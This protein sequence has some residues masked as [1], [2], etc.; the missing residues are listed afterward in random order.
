[1]MQVSHLSRQDAPAQQ[2]LRSW[3][4]GIALFRG[5]CSGAGTA[6]RGSGVAHRETMSGDRLSRSIFWEL[7]AF[8]Q[9]DLMRVR[10]ACQNESRRLQKARDANVRD[11][12]WPS[13]C[14]DEPG[15]GRR[16]RALLGGG[17]G[18]RAATSETEESVR[19]LY[20]LGQ[21]AWRK[22]K[23]GRRHSARC[24][25]ESVRRHEGRVLSSPASNG[26]SPRAG[27]GAIAMA[28]G[29]SAWAASRRRQRRQHARP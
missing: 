22:G 4:T 18:P 2:V 15:G 1:M 14:V 29:Q 20:G 25:E 26:W 17:A 10:S 13:F 11:G 5:V 28:Q 27:R 8:A 19:V 23:G 21:L 12:N 16:G 6:H 24:T 7:V 3:W 9:G